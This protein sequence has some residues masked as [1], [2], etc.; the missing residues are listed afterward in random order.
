ML[1]ESYTPGSRHEDAGARRVAEILAITFERETASGQRWCQPRDADIVARWIAR[2]GRELGGALRRLARL[3]T[4]LKDADGRSYEGFLYLRLPLLRLHHFRAA[5][6]EAHHAGRLNPAIYQLNTH[7]LVIAHPSHG[8]SLSPPSNAFDIDYG[9]MPRLCALLDVLHNALGY[10]TV[11]DLLSINAGLP[12]SYE[13]VARTLEQAFVVWLNEHLETRH[14]LRQ[15]QAIRSYLLR[16]GAVEPSQITDEAILDF[17]RAQAC[18]ASPTPIDG[19]RVFGAAA[20]AMLRY[21]QA[22]Y[23]AEVVDRVETAASLDRSTGHSD[24]RDIVDIVHGADVTQAASDWCSPLAVLQM[25][26][27]GTVKWLTNK[28][29]S[30]LADYLGGFPPGEEPEVAEAEFAIQTSWATGLA[31]R[32]RFDL[33]FC[34][35]LLRA[36]VFGSA[37]ASIIARV[38]KRQ[39]DAAYMV[40]DAIPETAYIDMLHAYRAVHNQIQIECEAALHILALDGALEALILVEALAG[41]EA[42]AAIRKAAEAMFTDSCPVASISQD[43]DATELTSGATADDPDLRLRL[44]QILS[45]A[46]RDSDILPAGT[47]RD[48]FR[49]S[50]LAARRMGRAGFRP[51]GPSNAFPVAAFKSAAPALTDV[52]IELRRL[53]DVLNRSNWDANFHDDRSKFFAVFSALYNADSD[54]REAEVGEGSLS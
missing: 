25:P 4:A 13:E 48:L 1:I 33:R 19:F 54:L 38:R 39:G 49:T 36:A 51:V 9:Q 5:L 32:E 14:H 6:T 10:S 24:A 42:I 8:S 12:V 40:L 7:G 3:A 26:P 2:Q 30:L 53:V 17:W 47:A 22:L 37:Q 34:R 27:A 11:A 20:R 44:S 21:R 46:A 29:R 18:D 35:T 15:A 50:R 31:G 23:D 43:L 52:L 41:S 16:R 45:Q 28:E